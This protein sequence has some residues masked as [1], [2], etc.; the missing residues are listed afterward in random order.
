[1]APVSLLSSNFIRLGETRVNL[2]ER[3]TLAV[4]SDVMGIILVVSVLIVV[5]RASENVWVSS[6]YRLALWISGPPPKHYK[7]EEMKRLCDA[8]AGLRITEVFGV[9]GYAVT[10][11]ADSISL[12]EVAAGNAVSFEAIGGCFPCLKELVG[13]GFQFVETYYISASDR[14]KKARR[15]GR[16][17]SLYNVDFYKQESGLYRYH[18]LRRSEDNKELCATFDETV[19]RVAYHVK[20]HAI[21]NSFFLSFW[22]E[23]KKY[24][25][26]LSGRCVS[27]ERIN[28]FSAP[29]TLRNEQVYLDGFSWRFFPGKVRR[30]SEVV[31]VHSTGE[32]VAASIAYRYAV[33]LDGKYPW[34]GGAC[35]SSQLPD[36]AEILHSSE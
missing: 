33:Y 35:G 5:V 1:M 32:V 31:T 12:E 11:R 9:E 21:K 22:R 8:D 18:L 28:H 27:V 2:G 19:E 14:A 20:Y 4:I 30:E 10:P 26:E 34:Q 3:R 7:P 36:I 13:D 16:E 17:A 23:Y 29:Y 15:H 24:K 25:G 6:Y